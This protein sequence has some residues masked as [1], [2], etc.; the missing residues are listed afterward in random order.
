[1]DKSSQVDVGLGRAEEV[2]VL[3]FHV[4]HDHVL[5]DVGEGCSEDGDVSC[6]DMCYSAGTIHFVM[7]RLE[8]FQE[9]FCDT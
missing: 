8:D 4:G 9:I 6:V 5:H 2:V 7:G 1:M 3:S